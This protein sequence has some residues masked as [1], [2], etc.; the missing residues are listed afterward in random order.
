MNTEIKKPGTE[1]RKFQ[2]IGVK[3][4]N[5][6]PKYRVETNNGT[7]KMYEY[8]MTSKERES[9]EYWR[10]VSYEDC[11]KNPDYFVQKVLNDYTSSSGT[12]HFLV[13]FNGYSDP[14]YNYWRSEAELYQCK[15]LIEEY[16][17]NKKG[18]PNTIQ[19]NSD[20]EDSDEDE[21][22]KPDI[23]WRDRIEVAR[24]YDTDEDGET[25]EDSDDDE[26]EENKNTS[27]ELDRSEDSS[28]DDEGLSD[29]DKE[30]EGN[31]EVRIR[32][33]QTLSMAQFAHTTLN[34]SASR[35]STQ[36][37]TEKHVKVSTAKSVASPKSAKGDSAS[38][39]DNSHSN[40]ATQSMKHRPFSRVSENSQSTP[41]KDSSHSGMQEAQTP[42]RRRLQLDVVPSSSNTFSPKR[43]CNK[44]AIP[45]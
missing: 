44:H 23:S 28:E 14:H 24:N 12:K 40:P 32:T 31:T 15:N 26:I 39:S 36:R 41:K 7:K 1:E 35:A 2:I 20:S 22:I 3:I 30:R 38:L 5:K 33:H 42:H 37:Q 11:F 21:Y 45:K 27:E 17:N 9:L 6:S 10:M 18:R 16:Q 13:S 25:G 4:V 8:E 34:T 19:P 43:A 29:D